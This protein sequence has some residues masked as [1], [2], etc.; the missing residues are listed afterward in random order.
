M[1]VRYLLSQNIRGVGPR[2]KRIDV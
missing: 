2:R 1:R